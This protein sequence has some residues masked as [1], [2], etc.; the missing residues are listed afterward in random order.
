MLLARKQAL[1][2]QKAVSGWEIKQLSMFTK[3]CV[4]MAVG[5]FEFFVSIWNK[6]KARKKNEAFHMQ[7]FRSSMVSVVHVYLCVCWT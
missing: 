2:L 1:H 5:Q 3:H 7:G 6:K 4:N